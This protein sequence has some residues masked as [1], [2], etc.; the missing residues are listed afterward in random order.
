[1]T[2]TVIIVTALAIALP[3]ILLVI[4]FSTVIPRQRMLVRAKEILSKMPE[5]EER[6]EYLS[7]DTP[8]PR[9]KQ[10]AMDAKIVEME[11]AG[12]VYL[13]ASE[14]N[15][16]KTLFSLGGG[17]RLHFVREVSRGEAKHG[18]GS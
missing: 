13:K 6:V 15:P 12:W 18:S 16:L 7:F 8:W 3:L 11:K 2:Y 17:L 4:V 1:M 5:H 10:K 9:A 14:A